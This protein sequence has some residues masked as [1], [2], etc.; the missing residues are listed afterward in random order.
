MC[1]NTKIHDQVQASIA[2]ATREVDVA[3]ESVRAMRQAILAQ[4]VR[5]TADLRNIKVT[6]D[7]V[8]KA[9]ETI[10]KHNADTD[11]GIYLTDDEYMDLMTCKRQVEAIHQLVTKLEN[12]PT[13]DA[14]VM[15][16]KTA[17]YRIKLALE[18]AK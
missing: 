16:Y 3:L 15:S 4:M 10:R 12:D 17:A 7:D 8:A 18:G 13:G 1:D 2:T 5:E 14:P 11:R 6:S 9:I